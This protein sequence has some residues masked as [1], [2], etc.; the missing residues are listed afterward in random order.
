ML[1]PT[2]IIPDVMVD[3]G[4]QVA[5][6][7]QGIPDVL[8]NRGEDMAGCRQHQL[9][10]NKMSSTMKFL[11]LK[12]RCVFALAMA[13]LVFLQ[14]IYIVVTHLT[15]GSTTESTLQNIY[16]LLNQTAGLTQALNETSGFGRFVRTFASGTFPSDT[17]K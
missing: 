10:Y 3:H 8:L 13:F 15:Q 6:P 16:L 9:A 1:P 7:A 11:I 5:P 17:L 14:L 4:E 2:E 12:Y